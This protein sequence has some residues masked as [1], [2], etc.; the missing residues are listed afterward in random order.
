MNRW[1]RTDSTDEEILVFIRRELDELNSSAG[2]FDELN[3]SGELNSSAGIAQ[4]SQ[5]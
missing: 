1:D 5:K 4:G 3:S 2:I